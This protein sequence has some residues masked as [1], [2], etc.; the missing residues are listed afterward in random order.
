MNPVASGD[1]W[2]YARPKLAAQYLH[3]FEIGLISARGLFAPR[4]M[5]KTQFLE[6]DLVP[7]AI[8]A[9]YRTAYVSLWDARNNPRPAL[10]LALAWTLEPQGWRALLE[11]VRGP[12][13]KLKATAKIGELEGALEAELEHDPRLTAPLLSEVLRSID[14]S[15]RRLLLI[16]DEAQV[17]AMREHSELAHALRAGLDTRKAI[18]KVIFAGSSE[19][20]LRRMFGCP[21]EPF[22]NWAPIE[23]FELLGEELVEA[24]VERVNQ[25]SRFPLR[26][27]E[28]LAAFDALK[29][30]PEFFRRYLERYLADAD[31]GAQAALTYTRAQVFSSAAHA[32]LWE[33]LLPSDQAVLRLLAAGV[34]DVCS[35]DSRARLARALGLADPVAR[36]TPQ[37]AL[38]RLQSE[39]LVIR[40]GHGRYEIIDAALLEWLRNL[41]LEK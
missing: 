32:E 3:M 41:D 38:K 27:D 7:A 33:R 12:L 5:G 40:T 10:I 8:D 11:H 6:K 16:L 31:S 28:A 14:R 20:S 26:L 35:E 22:Y 13:K 25:L 4:R 1:P 15:R 18:I 19:G 39:E 17:L 24:L 37:H 2:H 30:T 9:G 21:S 34:K 29:R 36:T 23:P